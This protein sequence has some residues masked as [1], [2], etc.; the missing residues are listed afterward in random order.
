[1]A[2]KK[3]ILTKEQVEHIS[4]G[5][6]FVYLS[7]LASKPDLGDI[8]S[9]EITTD[10]SIEDGYPEP[11]TTDD[12]A[13]AM[14]CDWRGNAKLAGMGAVQMRECT[15]KEWTQRNI[16]NEEAEHGN[17]RLKNRTF[18][19]G[20]NEAGKSY[21]A[22]KMARSR[23]NA[24]EKKLNSTDPQTREE[25][26]ETLRKMHQNWDNLDTAINQYDG[27]KLGDK[28]AQRTKVGPKIASAPKQS[29]NGKAH[30]PKNGVFLN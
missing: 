8:Y 21:D 15:K 29:G 11:T 25:G 13:N 16:Y 27:A 28:V 14:T 1:M 24:A 4:E 19:A 30:S 3:L 23:V 6:D 9:T 2:K 18:G 17:A 10:G 7:N 20:Y 5:E 12:K 26:S 22:V